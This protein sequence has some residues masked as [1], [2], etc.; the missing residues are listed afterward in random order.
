MSYKPDS[1]KI[2]A[3]MKKLPTA[4]D[5]DRARAWW[6][7]YVFRLDHVENAARI[8]NSG[9]VLSRMQAKLNNVIVHDSAAQSYIQNLDPN[10]QDYVR[11]YF[12]PLT[13]TQYRN[14]GIRPKGKIELG[15]HMPVPIFLLFSSDILTLDGVHFVEGRL[16]KDTAIGASI[17]FLQSLDFGDVYHNTSVGSLQSSPPRRSQIL[18]ARHSEVLIGQELDLQYLRHI[19]C[20]STAERETLIN[21]LESSA[22]DRCK[23]LISVAPNHIKLFNKLGTFVEECESSSTQVRFKFYSSVLDRSWRGPFDL[24][25]TWQC[26]DEQVPEY[27]RR[28]FYVD[29]KRLILDVPGNFDDYRI[30]LQLNGDLVYVGRFHAREHIGDPF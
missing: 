5:L 2:L 26:F 28:D 13:P 7:K 14:E 6:P 9:R 20:R 19:V 3:H 23:Q 29:D 12:R 25:I 27:T 17:E 18:N 22:L 11:M 24:R 15:A 21:L 1:A 10:L 8:L 30:N 4:L 16:N